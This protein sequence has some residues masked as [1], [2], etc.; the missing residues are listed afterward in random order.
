MVGV[1]IFVNIEGG[2]ITEVAISIGAFVS[3]S[4]SRIIVTAGGQSRHL[5]TSLYSRAA[6]RVLMDVEPMQARRETF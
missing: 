6:I 5:F 2:Q 3:P 1:T 4:A